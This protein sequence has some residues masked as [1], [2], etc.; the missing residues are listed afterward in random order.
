MKRWKRGKVKSEK[1]KRWRG[2]E[3]ERWKGGEV[4]RWEKKLKQ[5]GKP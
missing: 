1:G 2:G 3:V 4:E 5:S